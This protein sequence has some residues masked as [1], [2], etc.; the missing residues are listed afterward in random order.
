[1]W[2]CRCDCGREKAVAG[3]DLK[4]GHTK[5]CGCSWGEAH[6]ENPRSGPTP[7][8]VSWFQMIQRCTN[9]RNKRWDRY[10]GRGIRVCAEWRA[11]YRTFLA[12]VGR[13]PSAE[14]SLDRINNDGDYEPGN[15]RWA[16]RSQQ[17]RNRRNSVYV[18]LDGLTLHASDAAERLRLTPRG[19]HSRLVRGQSLAD[20][21][22]GFMKIGEQ[23]R[24][25]EE[26]ERITGLSRHVLKSRI[27]SGW[28]TEDVVSRPLGPNRFQRGHAP[29]GNARKRTRR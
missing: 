22:R 6:G 24:S 7:E 8:Y 12:D 20:V 18:D 17:L 27:R 9:S 1:M 26:W 13:R 5:T 3:P 2:L 15:V 29:Y 16:T 4:R 21:R 19:L 28:R 10:G 11:S 14:H 23:V 25:C